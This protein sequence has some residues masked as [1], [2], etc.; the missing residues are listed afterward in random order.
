MS[1]STTSDN[2]YVVV[3][4]FAWDTDHRKGALLSATEEIELSSSSCFRYV[5]F[6][7]SWFIFFYNTFSSSLPPFSAYLF[8]YFASF[9]ALSVSLPASSLYFLPSIRLRAGRLGK[10]VFC[11]GM[12][13]NCS[14][15]QTPVQ[16]RCSPSLLCK[17]Y[18]GTFFGGKEP[19]VKRS[20]DLHLKTRL[21]MPG[22]PS[23]PPF[24]VCFYSVMLS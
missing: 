4:F 6:S 9:Y 3:N 24:P 12:E 1:H 10:P 11:T 23:A 17:R 16:L 5:Y 18:R 21:Q 13:V 19:D 8:V 15:A 22:A 2:V 20:T 7:I 14:S